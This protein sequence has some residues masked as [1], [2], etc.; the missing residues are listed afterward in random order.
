MATNKLL[1]LISGLLSRDLSLF[2]IRRRLDIRE[3]PL[4]P[5]QIPPNQTNF[6]RIQLPQ[7]N[8]RRCLL[9]PL[10]APRN[11]IVLHFSSHDARLSEEFLPGETLP[12]PAKIFLSALPFM[13]LPASLRD[14]FPVLPSGNQRRCPCSSI[15]IG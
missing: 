9:F 3:Y 1:R 15:S 11:Q 7:G 5:A 13:C 2:E 14:I 4:H 6:C 12:V 8:Q 10:R